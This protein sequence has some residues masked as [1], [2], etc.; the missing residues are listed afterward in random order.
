MG[1]KLVRLSEGQSYSGAS[2]ES[3]KTLSS[4]DKGSVL[5]EE[6]VIN[7]KIQPFGCVKTHSDNLLT[8]A[9]CKKAAGELQ[10]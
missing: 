5:L 8:T 7:P 1:S 10:I 2:T 3:S 6:M 9:L 4:Y